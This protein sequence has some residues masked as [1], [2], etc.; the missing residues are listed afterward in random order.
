M[1][2]GWK[3]KGKISRGCVSELDFYMKDM[4]EMNRRY[5]QLSPGFADEFTMKKLL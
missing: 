2:P 4:H 3:N 1:R 5:R